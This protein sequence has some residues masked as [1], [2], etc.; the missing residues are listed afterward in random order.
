MY[1]D[2]ALANLK[3]LLP[4][5]KIQLEITSNGMR[6]KMLSLD[7]NKIEHMAIGHGEN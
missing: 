2:F 6:I 7:T 5:L 3:G 4:A 1:A